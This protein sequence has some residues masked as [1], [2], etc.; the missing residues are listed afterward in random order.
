MSEQWL[1]SA[2]DQKTCKATVDEL[3]Q[4]YSLKPCGLTLRRTVSHH[5]RT[6]SVA[7]RSAQA[8]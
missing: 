3:Q 1:P 6:G 4:N 5:C 8:G 7:E 2:S